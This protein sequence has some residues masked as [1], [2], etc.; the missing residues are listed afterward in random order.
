MDLCLSITTSALIHL[1]A[2]ILAN[3][4]GSS[5]ASQVMVRTYG[6]LEW[7]TNIQSLHQT[8]GTKCSQTSFD[9]TFLVIHPLASIAKRLILPNAARRLSSILSTEI[10][11]PIHFLNHRYNPTDPSLPISSLGPAE[12]DYEYVKLALQEYPGRSWFGYAALTA[13]VA[14]HAAE[15]MSI[16]WNTWLRGLFGRSN[17]NAK[18]RA[19]AATLVSLPMII[20]DS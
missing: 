16:V 4:D 14:W 13:C 6:I 5:L 2:P 9:E 18:A 7:P 10:H 17:I 20:G 8:F 19:I 11:C 15:G 3:W 12:L 1:T